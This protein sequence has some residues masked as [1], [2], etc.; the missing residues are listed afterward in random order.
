[1]SENPCVDDEKLGVAPGLSIEVALRGAGADAG[2]LADA[3]CCV[4][5][6]GLA[7]TGRCVCFA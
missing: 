2:A 6:L 3:A 5:P 4:A 7:N 1:M